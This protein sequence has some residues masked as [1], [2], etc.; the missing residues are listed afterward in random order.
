MELEHIQKS[1]FD[2]IFFSVKENEEREKDRLDIQK[3]I[4]E[5]KNIQKDTV[6]DLTSLRFLLNSIENRL[7]NFERVHL[8][9]ALSDGTHYFCKEITDST[10]NFKKQIDN[11]IDFGVKRLKDYKNMVIPVTS[12]YVMWISLIF[13][14]LFFCLVV[15]Y[16]VEVLKINSL[17]WITVPIISLWTV[18]TCAIIYFTIKND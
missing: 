5:I 7:S 15:L 13:A 2:N 14:A 12:Y 11:T 1:N 8:P 6:Q 16:D 10:D 4:I 9:K 18:I 3:A 17:S